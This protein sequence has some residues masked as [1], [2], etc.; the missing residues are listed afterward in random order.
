MNSP[1]S[2][3]S[4]DPAPS[5]CAQ[6]LPLQTPLTE[7]DTTS[8]T[9]A[10]RQTDAHVLQASKQHHT[11]TSL[12]S[13]CLKEASCAPRPFHH[14]HTARFAEDPPIQSRQTLRATPHTRVRA[15]LPA[16]RSSHCAAGTSSISH[17]ST[18]RTPKEPPLADLKTLQAP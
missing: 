6:S 14:E 16:L 15:V 8:Q 13:C 2:L 3:S 4:A 17:P 1:E 18:L 11:A 7:P 5:R 10:P 9:A 12:L